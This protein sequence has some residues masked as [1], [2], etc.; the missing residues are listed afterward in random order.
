VLD[1]TGNLVW[2]LEVPIFR[3]FG[4]WGLDFGA[5][6]ATGL[7]INIGGVGRGWKREAAGGCG[8]YSAC[9]TMAY[10]YINRGS[11]DVTDNP[12]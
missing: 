2:D 9:P 4:S 11:L 7:L 12:V 10:F 5:S 8:V 1:V 3:G 6:N